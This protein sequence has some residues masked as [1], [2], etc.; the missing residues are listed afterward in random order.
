MTDSVRLAGDWQ[1]LPGGAARPDERQSLYCQVQCQECGAA[2]LAAKFS[3]QHTSVQWDAT[4]VRQCAEF[5]RRRLAGE[6]TPL[7]ERCDA[8]RGSIE[9]AALDGRLPV[10]P[11]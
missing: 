3:S 6:L 4:A 9:I 10:S 1:A 7:I 5:A 11:P 2:V 8:M